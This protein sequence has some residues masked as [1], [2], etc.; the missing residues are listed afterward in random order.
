MTPF[1]PLSHLRWPL[2]PA[3]YFVKNNRVVNETDKDSD[4]PAQN[5]DTDGDFEKLSRRSQP[6]FLSEFWL[7]FRSTKKW[8]LWPILIGILI[9]SIFVLVGNSPLAPFFYPFL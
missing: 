4:N 2:E 6:G 7:F 8:W 3:L 9:I 1:M 5:C